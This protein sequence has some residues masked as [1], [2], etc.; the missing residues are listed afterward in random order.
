MMQGTCCRKYTGW[1]SRRCF[2]FVQRDRRP[3]GVRS[4][5][6]LAAS[7]V[8]FVPAIDIPCSCANPGGGAGGRRRRGSSAAIVGGTACGRQG[9]EGD[10]PG[11]AS[12]ALVVEPSERDVLTGLLLA[13]YSIS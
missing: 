12:R 8:R 1:C 6:R 3:V 7:Y 13:A 10:P 11:A 5:R 4:R 9:P 2:R